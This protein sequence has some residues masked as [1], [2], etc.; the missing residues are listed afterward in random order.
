MIGYKKETV[1][2]CYVQN[3][4]CISCDWFNAPEFVMAFRIPRIICPKCG[5][6]LNVFAGKFEIEMESK[7]FGMI[8]SNRYINFIKIVPK[9][10]NPDDPDKTIDPPKFKI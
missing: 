9:H 1:T 4:C 3:I 10:C 8:K 2:G 6:S 5:N 7:W